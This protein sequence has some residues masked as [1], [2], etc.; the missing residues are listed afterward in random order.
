MFV[1]SGRFRCLLCVLSETACQPGGAAQ[2]GC[3]CEKKRVCVR[4]S[5]R[6][7]GILNMYIDT[8][9]TKKCSECVCLWVG[10]FN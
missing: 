2:G 7:L 4:L 5:L 10:I 9:L 6:L 1:F 8:L 3:V